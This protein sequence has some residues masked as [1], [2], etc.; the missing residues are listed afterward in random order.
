[1]I[2]MILIKFFIFS[3]KINKVNHFPALRAPFRLIFL[4][5][6]LIEVEV[7]LLTNPGKMS[8]AN[9]IAISVNAFF[10]KLPNQESKD[11]RN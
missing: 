9:E 6:L 2:F 10:S 4:L 11:I 5:K 7:K 1:M 8:L 3:F